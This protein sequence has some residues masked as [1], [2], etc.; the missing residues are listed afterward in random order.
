VINTSLKV[1]AKIVTAALVLL[2][3]TYAPAWAQ[4]DAPETGADKQKSTSANPQGS[5]QKLLNVPVYPRG[6]QSS[7]PLSDID[8][9][10]DQYI[11]LN[12]GS[13]ISMAD[14]V[15]GALR[16]SDLNREMSDLDRRLFMGEVARNMIREGR[17][18]GV[19]PAVPIKPEAEDEEK[20]QEPEAGQ[21]SSGFGLFSDKTAYLLK[22]PPSP[23][24]DNGVLNGPPIGLFNDVSG[25]SDPA[26]IN[27][28][29]IRL[30]P[31]EFETFLDFHR[32]EWQEQGT[33][34]N[35]LEKYKKTL[36]AND[37]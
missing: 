2:G 32:H 24:I 33:Y 13:V 3:V 9:L 31:D 18:L 27:G 16:K 10:H 28:G 23:L 4:E 6:S 14:W 7:K 29:K 20:Y 34:L 21:P 36:K 37:Q 1:A 12:D 25:T 11:L 19:R 5:S 15:L 30:L 35:M 8:D 26:E 17:I 22:P